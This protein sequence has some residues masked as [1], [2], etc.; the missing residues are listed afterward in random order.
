[1]CQ[2][3]VQACMP[4]YIYISHYVCAVYPPSYVYIRCEFRMFR[5]FPR[6]PH[7]SS[8]HSTIHRRASSSAILKRPP[9][10]PHTP[11]PPDYTPYWS[12]LDTD[13]FL[14]SRRTRGGQIC[15]LCFFP[16][17]FLCVCVCFLLLVCVCVC[18]LLLVCVCVCV[19]YCL[20]VCVCVSYC[21]LMLSLCPISCMIC[22]IA[23]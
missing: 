9:P 1:M 12:P 21:F 5:I 2:S 19:S 16:L 15:T 4:I 13:Y 3:L 14:V 20:C 11:P 17:F 6:I 10:P 22:G 8:W 23:Y 7:T 18:F